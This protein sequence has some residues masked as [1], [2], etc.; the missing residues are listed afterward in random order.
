VVYYIFLLRTIGWFLIELL[1]NIVCWS[2]GWVTLKI[3]TLG[4]Y[5]ARNT[6]EDTVSFSGAAV[7]I[8]LLIYITMY[9]HFK[10]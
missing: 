4:K 1:F 10:S 9:Y 7:L 6:H 2:I 8:L 3:I 5:S